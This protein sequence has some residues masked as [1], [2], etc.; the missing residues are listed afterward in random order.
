MQKRKSYFST[1]SHENWTRDNAIKWY[2]REFSNKAYRAIMGFIT[3]DLLSVIG[4]SRD[5]DEVDAAQT[6]LNEFRSKKS[7]KRAR[8]AG[9]NNNNGPIHAQTY[10]DQR[11]STN[12][13]LAKSAFVPTPVTI[14][15]SNSNGDSGSSSSSNNNAG[16]DPITTSGD[17]TGHEHDDMNDMFRDPPPSPTWSP[18]LYREKLFQATVLALKK[19]SLSLSEI[20]KI[21]EFA[22]NYKPSSAAAIL[23]NYNA[24]LISSDLSELPN[25]MA[26]KTTA[27]HIMDTC[28]KGCWKLLK[29]ELKGTCLLKQ[30]I[31][32][33]VSLP[34]GLPSE[35]KVMFDNIIK[36][37]KRMV[38]MKMV[39]C[40][41][42]RLILQLL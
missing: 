29:R 40:V 34:S 15:S 31:D 13:T 1:V 35:Y 11:G 28:S 32:H 24:K 12:I 23:D 22:R 36:K 9:N 25:V 30:I 38:E 17:D 16:G 5:L 10:N 7:E 33:T 6:L 8:I 41:K 27:S 39:S 42:N 19:G 14:T 20:S 18:S 37:N 4:K 26:L 2:R 21:Q 3:S